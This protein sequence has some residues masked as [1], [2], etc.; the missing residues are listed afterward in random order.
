MARSLAPFI[1][2]F[3]DAA[4][5]TLNGWGRGSYWELWRLRFFSNVLATLI[6]VPP[7]VTWFTGGLSSL[8]AMSWRRFAE[9][10]IF[11]LGLLCVSLIAFADSGTNPDWAPVLLY[12]PLPFLLWAAVRFGPRGTSTSILFVALLSIWDAV[13]GRGPFAGSSTEQNALSIQLFLIVV[14]VPLLTLAAVMAERRRAESALRASEERLAK[15]FRF[16]PDAVA[17]VRA[18]NGKVIDVNDR[19]EFMFGYTRAEVR[20]LSA[21][22]LN[23]YVKRPIAATSTPRLTPRGSCATSRS[24]CAPAAERCAERC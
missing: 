9:G 24:T 15:A 17:M 1:A 13:H 14:S 16:G 19:W 23:L 8:R 2:S 6:L 21:S 10:G 22:E 12:A 7:I 20:G 4:F 3:L 5:V 11:T 18:D